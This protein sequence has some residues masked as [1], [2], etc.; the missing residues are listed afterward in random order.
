MESLRE[1]LV[2]RGQDSDRVIR[3]RMR[4]AR[5]EISH[6]NEFDHLIVNDRFEKALADLSSIIRSGQAPRERGERSNAEILAELLGTG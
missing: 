1:R 5:A 6:W 2:S 3:R 4:D